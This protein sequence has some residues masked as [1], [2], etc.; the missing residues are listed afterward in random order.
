MGMSVSSLFEQLTV[1]NIGWAG[2][3]T[4]EAPDTVFRVFCRPGI[5]RQT[6]IRFLTPQSESTAGRIVFIAGQLIRR[7]DFQTKTAVHAAR[8]K[9]FPAVRICFR[10]SHESQYQSVRK[11]VGGTNRACKVSLQ[12]ASGFAELI[13]QNSKPV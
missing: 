8:Q 13:H 11:K 10:C 12:A 5:S 7:T 4:G 3:F 2:R 6:P 9:I 1:R